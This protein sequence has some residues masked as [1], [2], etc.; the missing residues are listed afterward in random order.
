M[1]L[2]LVVG[3]EEKWEIKSLEMRENEVLV[4]AWRCGTAKDETFLM[5]IILTSRILFLLNPAKTLGSKVVQSLIASFLI[6][7]MFFPFFSLG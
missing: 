3:R 7:K 4:Y 1:G 6:K 2:V 5:I